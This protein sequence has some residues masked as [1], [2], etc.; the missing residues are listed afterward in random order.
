V[1]LRHGLLIAVAV[2]CTRVAWAQ[3]VED[4]IDVG[5]QFVPSLAYNSRED[6]L[7]G[8]A[9]YGGFFA[10]S[11]DSNKVVRSFALSYPRE[12]AYD[13]VDNKAWCTC[14]GTD[15]ESLAVIDGATHSLMKKI[16]MPGATKPVWD[17]VSMRLYVSCSWANSVAVLDCATDSVLANIPV[18]AEPESMYINTLRRKLYVMNSGE[19]TV[20]VV[21]MLTNQVS[22]TVIVG[23]NPGYGYYSRSVDK[24][25][26]EGPEQQC[27]VID[28]QSD[29][30]V[31]HITLPNGANYIDGATGNE[32]AGLV[33]LAASR[34]DS[35]Y[36]A[37]VSTHGDSVLVSVLVGNMPC[38]LVYCDRNDRLYCLTSFPDSLAI[39]SGDGTRVLKKLPVGGCPWVTALVPRQQRVYV[40][41]SNTRY[42]YVVKDTS[43]G[44]VEPQTHLLAF[45][46]ALTVTPNPFTR[47]LVV[48]LNS[49]IKSGGVA[50]L[51][52]QDGRLVRQARIP[53]G[54]SCWV[55]DGRD[56]F[57]ALLP[58]G[59][60]VLETGPGVRAKVAKLK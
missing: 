27:V 1:K 7:Y 47:S 20:S 50:R 32:N 12:V 53:A 48:S 55:W 5:G 30:V 45:R 42:V 46:G 13:S 16:Q 54:V 31:G 29:A 17:P 8:A 52:A 6:V 28:G 38:G 24:F 19:S 15:L 40:G 11:C 26:C 2:L 9:Y 36:V 14:W 37:T 23:E 18:G 22:A 51:Y 58:P 21:N 4:S 34:S 3:Y 39:M 56:D 60:Y 25:Y 43:L 41:H 10:I 44:V 33:Y 57:G 35:G 59:V 49:S